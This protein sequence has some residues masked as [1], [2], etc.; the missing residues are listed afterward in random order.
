MGSRCVNG[1][2]REALKNPG[3]GAVS[4]HSTITTIATNLPKVMITLSK[5]TEYPWSNSEPNELWHMHLTGPRETF[6]CL[7]ILPKK[8]NSY[9]TLF[10]N[11]CRRLHLSY[12]CADD[13]IPISPSYARFR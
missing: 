8:T 12:R 5:L 11:A 13:D 9:P 10:E 2:Q 7:R 3:C 6:W 4:T 1:H